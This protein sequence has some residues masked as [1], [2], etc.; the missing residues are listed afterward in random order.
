MRYISTINRIGTALKLLCKLV[1][2]F[3][4]AIVKNLLDPNI[5]EYTCTYCLLSMCK[6]S[7]RKLNSKNVNFAI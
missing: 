3:S 1:S 7:P 5:L 6:R 4:S 2:R